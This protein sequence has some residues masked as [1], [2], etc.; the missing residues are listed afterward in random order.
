MMW[1]IQTSYGKPWTHPHKSSM[2]N[3]K[4][5]LCWG[6]LVLHSQKQVLWESLRLPLACFFVLFFNGNVAVSHQPVSSQT[7]SQTGQ[8]Q[9]RS[10]HMCS[11]CEEALPLCAQSSKTC[12]SLSGFI[13]ASST[14]LKDYFSVSAA[15]LLATCFGSVL[16]QTSYCLPKHKFKPNNIKNAVFFISVFCAVYSFQ[17]TLVS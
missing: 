2:T 3:M 8:T 4:E 17:I 12:L 10:S 9:L 15:F 6:L 5:F 16:P 1:F 13:N 7:Q 14:T 11:L